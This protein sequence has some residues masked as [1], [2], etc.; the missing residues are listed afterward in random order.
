MTGKSKGKM[1]RCIGANF[2]GHL[3]PKCCI[4]TYL[5]NYQNNG[6]KWDR[7]P[8]RN[9]PRIKNTCTIISRWNNLILE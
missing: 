8:R 7:R 3:Y 1:I 9:F 2:S 4:S 5:S 6:P